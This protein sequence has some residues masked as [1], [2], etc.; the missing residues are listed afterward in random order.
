MRN[1]LRSLILIVL[2]GA[3]TNALGLGGDFDLIADDG[4]KYSLADSRG[5]VVVVSFGYT[6]CPDVCPTALSTIG[7]ALDRIGDDAEKVDPLFISLDPDRD[8]PEHLR[9]YTRFFHPRLRGLTGDAAQLK[10]VADLYHARYEFVGKGEKERYTLD[11]SASLYVIDTEGRML[12]IVPHGM[13]PRV[14]ADSLRIA[15]SI[16]ESRDRLSGH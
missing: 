13:P 16:G 12:R 15:I 10:E 6:S 8:T 5:Q 4:S 3:G 14:L 2:M 1:G 9:E 11:H 7:A